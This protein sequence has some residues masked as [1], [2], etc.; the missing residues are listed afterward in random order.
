[1]SV[2]SIPEVIL[3]IL[4]RLPASKHDDTSV[5]TLIA[6]TKAS[7]M[8]RAVAQTDSLW[9][10]HYRARWTRP[11]LTDTNEGTWHQ[12]YCLRRAKDIDFRS[13]LDTIIRVPSERDEAASV[14]CNYEGFAWDMLR[15]ELECRVPEDVSGIWKEDEEQSAGERWDGFGEEWVDGASERKSEHKREDKFDT[16]EIKPDWIQRRWWAKQALAAISRLDAML[17]IMRVFYTNQA[18]A[19]SIVN[20]HRFERGIIALSGLMGVN[21]HEM[22]HNYD[23][24]AQACKDSLVEYG[25]EVDATSSEFDLKTFSK[26][27]CDWMRTQGFRRTQGDQPYNDLMSSFPHAFMTTNRTSI[28]MSLV[29]TFV[30]I[31]TRLGFLAAPAGD[32]G[33]VHAWIALPDYQRP[34]SSSSPG[35]EEID[36][37]DE[38]PLRRLH[39]DVCYSETEPFLTSEKM[40]QT[41]ESLDVPQARWKMFMEPCTA[42]QANDA[43]SCERSASFCK[44]NINLDGALYTSAITLFIAGPQTPGAAQYLEWITAVTKRHY[45]LDTESVLRMLLQFLSDLRI[46]DNQIPEIGTHL[47]NEITK[48]RVS[49]VNVKK[50]KDKKYWVGM[51]FKHA[52]SQSLGLIVGWD[53]PDMLFVTGTEID[54]LYRQHKQAG[55]KTLGV[56]GIMIYVPE[57]NVVPLPSLTGSSEDEQK[58]AWDRVRALMRH[59]MSIIERTFTRVEVDEELG[60]VWFVPAVS[61]AEE[62]PEDTALGEEYMRR[63]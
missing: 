16:R 26:G 46:G 4:T 5:R 9:L 52:R 53:E 14:L 2:L 40:R 34:D 23:S 21:T 17:D 51:I 63:L 42:S 58:P 25:I 55:Y 32:V 62:Y 24:L 22:S 44:A 13:L 7:R 15:M 18:H 30:A 10:K 56:N 3:A 19:T 31:A 33:H 43:A 50:R 8:L 29:C 6:C 39:V 41:L 61:T 59:G 36:W 27:V 45:P 54:G 35:T 60:R 37:E 12:L 57:D 28:P 47:R 38:Q 20:A 48:L 1:M 49:S 11:R